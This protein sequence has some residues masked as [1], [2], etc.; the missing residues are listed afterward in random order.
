M[1]LSSIYG[2]GELLT[3]DEGSE[4]QLSMS[5][6]SLTGELGRGLSD[7]RALGAGSSDVLKEGDV[8]FK[9]L[10]VSSENTSGPVG[11]GFGADSD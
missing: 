2:C 7:K 5:I 11:A 1:C 9:L 8:E 4:L 3:G 10:E 6:S